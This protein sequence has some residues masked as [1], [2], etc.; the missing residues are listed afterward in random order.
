VR[1]LGM[2]DLELL[3]KATLVGWFLG[4]VIGNIL[5]IILYLYWRR[6]G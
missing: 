2:F 1:K 4:S 3:G 5:S 6:Q